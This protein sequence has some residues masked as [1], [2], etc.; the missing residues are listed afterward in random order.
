[1]RLRQ[2]LRNLLS[3]AF[4]F[5]EKGTVRLS[6]EAVDRAAAPSGV[7]GDGPVV[8]FR[9]IDT[10]IGIPKDKQ[11]II[12]EAFQQADGG[13]SRKYGGTGLGLAISREIAHLLGG[14][15]ALESEPGKGSTFT[16]YVPLRHTP[17][18]R[19]QRSLAPTRRAALQS[20]PA[21][22]EGGEDG[23]GEAAVER[24]A[25]RRS[26]PDD[27]S[28][29][30][31]GDRV[32]LIVEDDETFARTLLEHAREHGFR[33]VVA[34]EGIEAMEIARSLKPDAITL[35]LGLPDMDG[36]VLLDRLKHDPDTRHIPVHIISGADEERRG[37]EQGAVAVLTKPVDREALSEALT[38]IQQFLARRV[39]KL[40]VVEDDDVQRQAILELIGNGDVETT[41]V[42]S[43]EEALE[44]LAAETFDC[45]VVDLKLPGISGID[46]IRKVKEDPASK[47]LPIIVYTGAELSREEQVG[48]DHLAETVIVKDV[49]SPE[50]LLDETSLFLHRV[51]A[52][53]PERK[54]KMLRSLA[55]GDPALKGK[56]VLVV[57]DDVRNIFA[58]TSVLEQHEME[59]VY[60]ENGRAALEKLAEQDGVDVV[61]MD[62]MMPEMDGYEATRRIRK[63]KKHKHLPV[64]ALT[65]KA[66]KGDRD[67]CIEVGCSDYV[68]KP[69]D[70][71]Q[72]ISLLRV[73]LY[74]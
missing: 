49:R 32:L 24:A 23:D 25:P 26:I 9:V 6:I 61:L 48:L 42:A 74:R 67:K 37:L 70:P 30:E 8:A 65:A 22:I 52:D 63:L 45:M 69:V 56:K 19:P 10:G 18:R 46:L 28:A 7:V 71:D 1:M 64:I 21:A 36:W 3:N 58:I 20:A 33:G 40:L 16:L 51:E 55:F 15:L 62:I 57:D 29:I 60:A 53:L 50:R 2:V 12:F 47:R 4:K 54:R 5:T 17:R 11:Q 38:G 39:K 34:L 41:A 31:P 44:A 35:D 68:T 43:G 72:L 73:W 14:E 27:R 59:V 13:T 66:M